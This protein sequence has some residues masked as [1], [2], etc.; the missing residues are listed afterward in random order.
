MN[1]IWTW[2]WIWN[3]MLDPDFYLHSAAVTF[4]H[5][6][7][8]ANSSSEIRSDFETCG[9]DFVTYGQDSETCGQD[10]ETCGP[11]S[12]T[13]GPDSETCGPDSGTCGPDSGTCGPDSVTCGPGNRIWTGNG[14]LSTGT[15]NVICQTHIDAN[16]E[17]VMLR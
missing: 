14:G 3:E 12:E 7:H 15:S 13:C 8:S 6:R 2:I 16:V 5:P 1:G 17:A 9:P 11:D 10:S 4:P